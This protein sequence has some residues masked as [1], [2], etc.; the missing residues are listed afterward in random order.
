MS[1]STSL[2]GLLASALPSAIAAGWLLVAAPARAIDRADPAAA[3]TGPTGIAVELEQPRIDR[4]TRLTAAAGGLDL[5]GRL[6]HDRSTV[7]AAGLQL[8]ATLAPAGSSCGVQPDALY[9]DGF[10]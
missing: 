3:E 6:R 8:A 10:E 7:A 9:S 1:A 5:T 4:S 2:T